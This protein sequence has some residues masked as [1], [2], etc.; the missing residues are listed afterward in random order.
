MVTTSRMCHLW[1]AAAL[2]AILGTAEG[3]RAASEIGRCTLSFHEVADGTTF[4]TAC[5]PSFPGNPLGTSVC[6]V[7]LS[8]CGITLLPN[9]QIERTGD[10][11][12]YVA[13]CQMGEGASGAEG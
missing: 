5:I 13:M 1:C 2:C 11:R 6:Y 8:D 10:W 4:C 12:G 9:C 3:G 7:C